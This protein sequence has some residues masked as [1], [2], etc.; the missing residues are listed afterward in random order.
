MDPEIAMHQEMNDSTY[1]MLWS[2]LAGAS[3]E[4]L[5]WRPHPEANPVRWILGHLIWFEEWAADAIEETGRYGVDAGPAAIDV[6]TLDAARGHFDLARQRLRSLTA[7]LDEAGLAREIDYLGS[8][9]RSVR[10]LIRGHTLHLAGHRY[11]IRYVRGA[12][13]RAHGTSKDAFDPW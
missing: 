2:N 10:A 11:Q 8:G 6:E 9:P 13:A 4:E 7:T 12:Y 5:D 3:E 1:E